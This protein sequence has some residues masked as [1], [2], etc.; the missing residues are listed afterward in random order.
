MKPQF[1]SKEKVAI[2]LLNLGPEMAADILSNFGE[3]EI[4]EISDIIG[5]MR[6]VSNEISV[7]I[8]NEFKDEFHSWRKSEE[9]IDVIKDHRPSIIPFRYFKHLTSE[10]I[11][12]ILSGE[13]TQLIALILSYLEPHQAAEVVGTMSE[14]LRLDV[15]NK[16]ATSKPPPVQIIK[17]VDELLETKVISLGDRIDTPNERKYRAIAEILNRSD[18]VTEKT[19]MQRIK[20]EHPDIA[21]EIKMLM[22]VF[23]DLAIVEDKPLR[24]MLSETDTG[25]VAL[26]LKTASKG[27][28]DKIF[29]NMSK[30]MGDMVREEQQILGPKPLSEVEAAQKIIVDSLAKME[31]QGETV[32]GRAQEEGPLV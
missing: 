12:S 2:L 10:E 11:M 28:L 18:S 21:Q 29:S 17:Q 22:F 24:Q 7:G 15:L 27:V 23:E 8:L 1:S 20:E 5:R 26:A 14:E 4:A 32:R 3:N 25:T 30:R 19:I 13:H 9:I 6:S 31:A 16:M